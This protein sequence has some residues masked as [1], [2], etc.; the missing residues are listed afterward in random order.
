VVKVPPEVV[1]VR[2][3]QHSNS[4][5]VEEGSQKLHY[6]WKERVKKATSLLL[7]KIPLLSCAVNLSSH[8]CDKY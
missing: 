5:L 6:Q 4:F 7:V 3:K 1:R 2:M 8:K